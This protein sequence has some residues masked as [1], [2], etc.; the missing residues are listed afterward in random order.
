MGSGCKP[1]PARGNTIGSVMPL[2]K[3]L[4]GRKDIAGGEA[5]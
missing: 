5:P 1:E 3:D 4:K 2:S